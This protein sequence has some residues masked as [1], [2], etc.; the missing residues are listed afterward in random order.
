[1][2][3]AAS[4]A[5]LKISGQLQ[6]IDQWWMEEM[7]KRPGFEPGEAVPMPAELV[8]LA[9]TLHDNIERIAA[10]VGACSAW[11]STASAMKS[12][13]RAPM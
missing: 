9:Q 11:F 5:L 8:A 6:S 3:K 4:A 1:M 10:N 2:Q 7:V 13:Q 12:R